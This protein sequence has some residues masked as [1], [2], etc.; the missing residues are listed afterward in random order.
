MNLMTLRSDWRAYI[1]TLDLK[2]SFCLL[3][4]WTTPNKSVIVLVIDSGIFQ[5]FLYF[6]SSN[7]RIVIAWFMIPHELLSCF[8]SLLNVSVSII[9]SPLVW[10][11]AAYSHCG[12]DR[13]ENGPRWLNLTG[14]MC[15]LVALLLSCSVWFFLILYEISDCFWQPLISFWCCVFTGCEVPDWYCGKKSASSLIYGVNLAD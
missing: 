9:R 10:R 11:A 7:V 14:S 4:G 15:S 6:S 3:I 1:L 8:P 2:W 13:Q 12:C 5:E